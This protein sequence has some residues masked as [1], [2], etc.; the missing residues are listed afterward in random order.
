MGLMELESE[1][2]ACGYQHE[3]SS[4]H[5]I[6][7]TECFGVD[8]WVPSSKGLVVATQSFNTH[9]MGTSQ[10]AGLLLGVASCSMTQKDS[11]PV[12]TSPKVCFFFFFNPQD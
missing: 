12:V 9:T 2:K 1:S 11:Q 5:Q 10:Q 4:S 8:P 3:T 7:S 6:L